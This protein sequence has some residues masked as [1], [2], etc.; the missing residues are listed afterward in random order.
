MSAGNASPDKL[1]PSRFSHLYRLAFLLV[2]F[3][4]VAPLVGLWATPASWNYDLDHWFRRDA[5]LEGAQQ[6][7]VYGGNE[8]CLDC[9]EAASK[10]LASKPHKVLSCESCHGPVADHVRDKKK[11]A[12]APVDRSR[13]QCNNCHAEQ[14]NRPKRF[15]QFSKTGE[16]GKEVNKHMQLDDETPCLKCHDAHDPEA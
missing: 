5:L 14:I 11:F 16:I 6:P 3:L 1:G 13:W 9:H 2:V 10:M 8:S 12:N 7:L 15:P 4:I